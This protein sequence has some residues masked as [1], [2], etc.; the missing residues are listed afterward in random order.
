M[1]ELGGSPLRQINLYNDSL[2]PKREIFSARQLATWIVIAVIAMLV[3]AWWAVVETRKISAEVVSQASRQTVERAR[4]AAVLP[5]GETSPTPQQLAM[6][7]QALRTQQAQLE[8]R[9]GAR[10]QLRVGIANDKR[11]PSALMRLIATTIPPQ[12]W[13]T[14]IRVSGSKLD[15]IGK[16]LDPAAINVWLERL[17]MSTYVEAKPLPVVR[18]DRVDAPGVA[19][20]AAPAPAFG[21]GL[22]AAANTPAVSAPV[23]HAFSITAALSSPFADD[24]ARP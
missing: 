7:E 5:A 8:A 22:V 3:I 15:V 19:P 2:I 4:K 6:G 13:V 14:E 18:V 11:G 1:A 9:R 23:V 16:T 20:V 12:V 21:V 17:R 10:D 24:G